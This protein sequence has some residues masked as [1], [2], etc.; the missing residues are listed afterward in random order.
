VQRS[1]LL[2]DQ[3]QE[4][5]HG[6]VGV[7]QVLPEVPQAHVAQGSEVAISYQPSAISYQ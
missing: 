1:Q 4:D 3:E 2:Y 7:Q 5:H 6:P